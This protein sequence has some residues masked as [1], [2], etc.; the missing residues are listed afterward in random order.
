MTSW[1]FAILLQSGVS[2]RRA[3]MLNVGCAMT[4]F[5]GLYLALSIATDAA[6]KQWIA[7]VTTA[8]FLYV[9]LAD[10]LP[11]MVHVDSRHPWLMFFLQNVGLLT[12]WSILLLLSLYEDCIHF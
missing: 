5:G 6:T 4:S 10:M 12:G 3:L 11:T 7:A 1:D 2:V 9:G 8:M